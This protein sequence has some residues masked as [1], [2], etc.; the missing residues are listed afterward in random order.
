MDINH[1]TSSI[2][3]STKLKER[4]NITTITNETLI[5]IWN[6]SYETKKKKKNIDFET[7]PSTSSLHLHLYDI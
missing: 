6:Q 1:Q 7:P 4:S 2:L 3:K 5:N